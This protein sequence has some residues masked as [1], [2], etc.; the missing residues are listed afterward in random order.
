MYPKGYQPVHLYSSPNQ[1]PPHLLAK[2]RLISAH[3]GWVFGRC[4]I[5]K[6]D[7]KISIKLLLTGKFCLIFRSSWLMTPILVVILIISRQRVGV[8]SWFCDLVV[9]CAIFGLALILTLS[10]LQP[11]KK[12][13]ANSVD[14]DEMTHMSHLI[15]IYTVCLLILPFFSNSIFA[16]FFFRICLKQLFLTQ[17]NILQFN[18]EEFASET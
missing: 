1:S 3:I 8:L 5:P 4:V 6:G 7:N 9:L 12:V 2:W 11:W 13:W 16:G 18:V 17:W 14:P 10:T 15:W